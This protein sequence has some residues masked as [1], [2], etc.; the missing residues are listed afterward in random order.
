MI[1]S[2]DLELFAPDLT[3][4]KSPD[5]LSMITDAAIGFAESYIGRPLA[6]ADYTE[7]LDGTAYEKLYVNNFPIVSVTSIK[8]DLNVPPAFGSD[9]LIPATDYYVDNE[10]GEITLRALMTNPTLSA[11]GRYPQRGYRGVVPRTGPTVFPRS[12]K[13]IQI[14]YRGGYEDTHSKASAIKVALL[15][16]AS[17]ALKYG[18]SGGV[19]AT[20]MSYLDT[21]QSIGFLQ[22]AN[23]APIAS[24]L[25][26]LATLKP[27]RF[28]AP[29]YP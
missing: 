13:A 20:S 22:N 2:T 3:D 14:V 24:A 6:A 29:T 4:G 9:T 10:S 12:T 28:F 18:P 1:E 11:Y 15:E 5:F 16:L 17:Y 27:Y 25:G 19:G 26:F 23:Q 8:M 21:S 7:V